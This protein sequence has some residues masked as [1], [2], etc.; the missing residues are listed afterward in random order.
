M[1]KMHNSAVSG[2]R[3]KII[4]YLLLHVSGYELSIHS[5]TRQKGEE[6]KT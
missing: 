6:G 5:H 2:R 3:V 1:M 4:E